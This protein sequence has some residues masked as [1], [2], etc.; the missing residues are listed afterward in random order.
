MSA[1]DR[2]E[3]VMCSDTS[4]NGMYLE[5]WERNPTR[6]LMASAFFSDL[7]GS[8]EFE[9]YRDDVPCGVE[10]WFQNEARRRLP[11]AVDELSAQEG[12]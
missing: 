5:L 1:D 3:L 6:S 4:R 2:Y 7:D 8:F 11:R 12:V 9:R 10:A